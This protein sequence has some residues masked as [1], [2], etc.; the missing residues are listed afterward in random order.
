MGEYS[1]AI[2]TAHDLFCKLKRECAAFQGST[3]DS[4]LAWNCAVTAWHLRE[5][6]W[7]ERLS[8]T[9]GAD[10]TLFGQAFTSEQGYQTELNRRC[11]KYKFLRDVC[12][13]SKHFD[14]SNPGPVNA[15]TVRPGAMP[16]AMKF[17]ETAFG[18]G[19]YFAIRLEDGSLVRFSGVL[20]EVMALW[21][22]VFKS[23]PCA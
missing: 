4:D 2:K 14:L 15:T 12:N 7:K 20:S 3:T 23:E 8:V 1:F 6:L 19:S 18:E 22:D 13:G 21:D 16:G 9:P 5:W 11:P 10:L 17:G